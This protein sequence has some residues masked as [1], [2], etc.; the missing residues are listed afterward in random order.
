MTPKEIHDI[1]SANGST[2]KDIRSWNNSDTWL[3]DITYMYNNYA[4][5]PYAKQ[6]EEHCNKPKEYY[7]NSVLVPIQLKRNIKK[8]V[9]HVC[10][11]IGYSQKESNLNAIELLLNEFYG[12]AF[13]QIEH[14]KEVTKEYYKKYTEGFQFSK[15]EA[16]LLK[17]KYPDIFKRI[18]PY[19][20]GL[21][22]LRK[23]N[24]FKLHIRHFNFQKILNKLLC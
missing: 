5:K 6:I 3:K 12:K 7:S 1:V 18:N 13:Y 17:S 24:L 22:I 15:K 14:E 9:K 23:S 2:S 11:N 8:T 20:F 10:K 16:L 21:L 4:I 19:L